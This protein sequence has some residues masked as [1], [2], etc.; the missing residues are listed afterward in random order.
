[1]YHRTNL[2]GAEAEAIVGIKD[3]LGRAAADESCKW[4]FNPPGAPHFGGVWERLIQIVKKCLYVVLK[5][6]SPRLEVLRSA[7]IEAEYIVN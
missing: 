4:H 3:E 5:Q 1:M 2:K 6:E 7:L